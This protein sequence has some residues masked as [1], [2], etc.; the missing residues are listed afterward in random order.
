MELDARR[1]LLGSCPDSSHSSRHA[2][3]V[4]V[5]SLCHK[6]ELVPAE[7]L[8]LVSCNT[9][10][11]LFKLLCRALTQQSWMFSTVA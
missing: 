6:Q 9:H 8:L 10:T 11:K 5:Q 7:R 3:V 2:V 4:T 1:L